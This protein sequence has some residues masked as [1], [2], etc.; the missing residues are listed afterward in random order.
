MQNE[1]IRFTIPLV[2]ITKKNHSQIIKTKGRMLVLP[3][4]QYCEYEK[5]CYEFMPNIDTIDYP[6]N[7]CCL[8]YM[9]TRRRV[10]L[11]N[12]LAA[13]CDILTKYKIIEDD[14]YKIVHSHD[15]SRVYYSKENPR[16][17][18]IITRAFDE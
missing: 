15:N 13:T 7:L 6:I 10:D 14:N 12:L 8:Y 2:P 3:S 4:K 17:E 5:Q 11:C 1:I 9:P 18:V 16:C